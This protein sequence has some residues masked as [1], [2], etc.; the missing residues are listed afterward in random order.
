MRVAK[1][2]VGVE[3]QFLEILLVDDLLVQDLEIVNDDGILIEPILDATESRFRNED[4]IG[5]CTSKA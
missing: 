3:F 4:Q 2:L 1:E 5:L